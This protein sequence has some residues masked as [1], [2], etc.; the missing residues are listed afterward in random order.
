MD[1]NAYAGKPLDLKGYFNGPKETR[2]IYK[3]LADSG[4]K[5]PKLQALSDLKEKEAVYRRK[6]TAA[7][8][9]EIIH[10]RLKCQ[11]LR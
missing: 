3:V 10:L 5:P 4:F 7:L 2:A 8:R 11:V 9:L 6:P 1:N